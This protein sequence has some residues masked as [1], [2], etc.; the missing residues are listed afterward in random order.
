MARKSKSR[1]HPRDWLFDRM[2]NFLM[3]SGW[4]IKIVDFRGSKLKKERNM[5]G[6]TD[7]NTETIYLDKNKGGP[8]VLVHELGHVLF[9]EFLDDEARNMSKAER[10]NQSYDKW[11]ELRVLEWEKYFFQSL[12]KEHIDVLRSF[13]NEAR[14]K[15]RR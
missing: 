6:L 8:S 4:R 9:Q 5:I 12:A 13:I 10:L 15:K 11:C 1:N 3:R 7:W 2:I 14:K